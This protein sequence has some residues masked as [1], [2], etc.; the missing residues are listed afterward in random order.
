MRITIPFLVSKTLTEQKNAK[1]AFS[2][3]NGSS[4]VLLF[5]VFSLLAFLFRESIESTWSECT[6][7]ENMEW[8]CKRPTM[9]WVTG[10][11]R[12]LWLSF[13]CAKCAWST[14]SHSIYKSTWNR[15]YFSGLQ[16]T[17]PNQTALINAYFGHWSVHCLFSKWDK[18]EIYKINHESFL[19]GVFI[20]SS[21]ISSLFIR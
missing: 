17:L 8:V 9:T 21:V 15:F 13:Y 7:N 2:L 18:N 20:W 6:T 12:I 5:Y 19:H 11:C 10:L 14:S 3:R 16:Q 1:K 4:H